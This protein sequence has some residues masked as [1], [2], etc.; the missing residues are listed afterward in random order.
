M[1]TEP[2]YFQMSTSLAPVREDQCCQVLQ[3][4]LGGQ[5]SLQARKDRGLLSAR[6]SPEKHTQ[7]TTEIHSR[8]L[9]PPALYA[10]AEL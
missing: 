8:Q 2:Y 7:F 4:V 5:G 3:A 9:L 10:K 1:S 6:R